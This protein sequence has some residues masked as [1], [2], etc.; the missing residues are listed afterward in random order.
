MKSMLGWRIAR[1]SMMTVSPFA[2]AAPA[3]AQA[4]VKQFD[5]P[6][7]SL[8]SAILEFSRQSDVMVVVSPDL[9][10]GKR[11]QAVMGTMPVNRAIEEL[12]KATHLRAVSNP[13]G[14]YRIATA[15][16]GAQAGGDPVTSALDGAGSNGPV[17]GG[18]SA[19]I[20]VTAQKR[21]ER[22]QDVPMAVS[23][24]SGNALTVS[25]ADTLQDV[26]NKVPGLQ[27]ISSG[28]ASNE[29]VIRGISIGGGINSSV[30]TY[31]DEVPYTSV[32]PFSYSNSLAPNFDTY[33]LSRI[34]VLRGPQGTLYGANALGGLLKYVTNAPD[35]SHFGASA[36]V[37]YSS[38][39]H[40]NQ[41]GWEAHGMVNVPLGST[42]ALRVVAHESYFP[43]FIDDPSRGVKDVNDV[44][45]YGV[46]AALLW[47]VT[48]DL[49]I[50]LSANY[51][52]LTADDTNTEDLVAATLQPL[53]GALTQ[54]RALAE[55]QRVNNQIYNAT[56]NWNLGFA[57]LLSS[58]SYAKADPFS[59]SDISPSFGPV[60]Q[61][62]FGGKLG[63]AITTSEPVHSW[64]QELRLSSPKGRS[65]EWMAG[66]YFTDQAADELQGLKA[67][68]LDTH[69]IIN[70]F[71]P[72]I[73]DY[74]ITSTY[75]EY[76][77][78][79]NLTY[80]L[81]PAFEVSAG[82]R[83][84][85]NKQNY[86]QVN[87]GLLAGTDSFTTKSD[88]NV[89]TYSADA[90]YRFDPQLMIYG[91]IATGFVPGGPNDILPGSTL[92]E[93][94]H[95]ST[96][97]NYELGIK[98][99]TLDGRLT[100]DLD[101][102]DVEWKDIQL[103][104]VVDNLFAI[105]NG[106]RARSRGIEGGLSL[107]PV[108]GLTLSF[109]GAY[110]DAHLTQDTPASFGGQDGDRLPLSPHVSGTVGADYEQPLGSDITGF[111][112]V[113]WHYNGSRLSPFEFGDPRQT[114]PS[115]SL[116]DLRAGLRFKGYTVSFYLKNI[117]DVRAINTV[118]TETLGGI[119]A[120]Q[121]SILTPRTIGVTLGAMF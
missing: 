109:N 44:R 121:A 68:D 89:F 38:V 82:G 91:R 50:N 113:E 54:E 8:S 12:L 84:S 16:N 98:G 46:R 76:A 117:G 74:H 90:K 41:T 19:D 102:F 114:L 103:F 26:V 47:E 80:H 66:F 40:S 71:R 73:G 120:L 31:V 72:V 20:I 70:G 23:V 42:A 63:G 112:G 11:S 116:V 17:T 37:G 118:S 39:D 61:G 55:T 9:T 111:G 105:T 101:V 4:Q 83:Y 10:R 28:P 67:V 56:I 110:T 99:S 108:K 77:G 87:S 24:I 95:S 106:G 78:F 6:A 51:Q 69:Q 29:L 14:G 25:H 18:E 79:G 52:H 88:Q 30:A 36:L 22:V 33:D 59:I 62:M 86:H 60:L 21:N 96:T 119:S 2:L 7:Q 58:T 45:R 94:F 64:T 53:H 97:T 13:A 85:T 43:G 115:Y 93:T 15:G 48:P 3:A 5:I 32:G 100:Y 1:L 35:P 92:P 49:R 65:L 75:R 81:S 57:S 34:E 104:A 107:V 27:L